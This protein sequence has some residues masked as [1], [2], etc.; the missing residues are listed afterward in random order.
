M[1]RLRLTLNRRLFLGLTELEAHFAH[2]PPGAGY[3][4]HLDSFQT[5]NLRRISTVT[6][7]NPAWRKGDGGELLIYKDM[8]IIA[9]VPPLA[10]SLVCF[11]STEIPHQVAVTHQDRTSIAGWFRVRELDTTLLPRE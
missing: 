9:Q 4:K 8:R 10:G 6:Y 1:D 5:N 2:Y 7:L 3:R 11:S